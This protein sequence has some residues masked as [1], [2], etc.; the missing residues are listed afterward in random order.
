MK[1]KLISAVIEYKAR[2]ARTSYPQGRFDK[3]GRWYPA[4]SEA[5][6]CC[7]D[8][9]NPSRRWPYSLMIHCRTIRH[10]AQLYDVSEGDL[11]RAVFR[12]CM[13]HPPRDNRL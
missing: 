8:I 5:C 2:K 7:E 13:L 6:T 9:R 4:E 11:R 10:I 12:D 1:D 3:A